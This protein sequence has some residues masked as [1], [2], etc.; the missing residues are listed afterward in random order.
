MSA[1]S[2]RF[3]N[4]KRGGL[5]D[6]SLTRSTCYQC[7]CHDRSHD[8]LVKKRVRSQ[9]QVNTRNRACSVLQGLKMHIATP[10]SPRRGRRGTLLCAR[11]AA[12]W[13]RAPRKRLSLVPDGARQGGRCMERRLHN[14][15]LHWFTAQ[16]L[17]S[18][19]ILDP[20]RLLLPRNAQKGFSSVSSSSNVSSGVGSTM[21]SCRSRA[22]ASVFILVSFISKGKV[23]MLTMRPYNGFQK[24]D[25][26]SEYSSPIRCW[27]TRLS[28]HGSNF[29]VATGGSTKT[30]AQQALLVGHAAKKARSEIQGFFW[31]V[32]ASFRQRGYVFVHFGPGEGGRP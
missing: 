20:Y 12:V 18:P 17:S 10:L 11:M 19:I 22:G 24:N 25:R 26:A 23:I 29:A 32:A 7:D 13:R 4:T 31:S 8:F 28:A 21:V 5:V 2:K 1:K 6:T 15:V 3:E 27:N 14:F 9:R 30:C 16:V